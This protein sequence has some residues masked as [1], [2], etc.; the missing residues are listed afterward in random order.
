MLGMMFKKNDGGENANLLPPSSVANAPGYPLAGC[1]P[2]E[3][4]SVSPGTWQNS[5]FKPRMPYRKE[6]ISDT[7]YVRQRFTLSD[8]F[9]GEATG[10]Q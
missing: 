1:S 6:T 10:P 7:F 9:L 3:P 8:T 2:A 4:T 5:R